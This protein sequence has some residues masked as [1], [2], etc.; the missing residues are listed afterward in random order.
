MANL[1]IKQIAKLRV[2][3]I[4]AKNQKYQDLSILPFSLLLVRGSSQKQGVWPVT[5]KY[6]KK[7]V[8]T[9]E[10]KEDREKKNN[11]ARQDQKVYIQRMIEELIGKSRYRSGFL[12]KNCSQK[13]KT[14][15]RNIKEM[16]Y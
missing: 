1:I 12:S 16:K 6:N 2:L 14:T 15:I 10:E 13:V 4:E 3:A 9:V 7:R 5:E 11:N 8:A